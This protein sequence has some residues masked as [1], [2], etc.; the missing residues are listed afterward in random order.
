MKKEGNWGYQA[1]IV[2]LSGCIIY[3]C[4]FYPVSYHNHRILSIKPST[5]HQ[6]CL[7]VT[8]IVGI[9]RIINMASQTGLDVLRTRTVVDCDT[10]DEEGT[11]SKYYLKVT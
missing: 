1:F 9:D 11:C 3:S 6:Y 8:T 4:H 5:H 7:P 2:H 10:M